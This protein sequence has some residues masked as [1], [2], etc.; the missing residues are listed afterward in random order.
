MQAEALAAGDEGDHA[1]RSIIRKVYLYLVLFVSVVGV[2]ATAAGLFNHASEGALW[3]R[4]DN[5]VRLILD[6]IELLFLFIGLGT[7]HGLM[8]GKDGKLASKALADKHAAFPVLV[9]DPGN[10]SFGQAILAALQKQ[11]PR[12][13]PLSRR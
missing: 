10:G 9:F 6:N 13:P 2:M 7:Y 1:R 12:L 5:L 3:H 11:T 4:P 8:L